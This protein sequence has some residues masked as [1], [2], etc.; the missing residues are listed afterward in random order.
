M[1]RIQN[2]TEDTKQTKTINL[3]DGTFFTMTIYFIPMQYGWFITE[4]T[5]QDFTVKGVRICNS[6]NMLHQFKNQIPFG[7]ACFTSEQRE[8]SQQ[9]DFFSGASQMFLLSEEEVIEYT[10]F[11][12]DG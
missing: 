3:P 6:P 2:I 5:Y 7:L 11:L 10:E 12:A 4:L 9:E 8:P 1:Q